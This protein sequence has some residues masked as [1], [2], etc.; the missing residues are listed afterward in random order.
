MQKS[1]K[2]D[3][4]KDVLLVEERLRCLSDVQRVPRQYKKKADDY[5]SEG[6]RESHSKRPRLCNQEK[7]DEEEDLSTLSADELR[8]RLKD[9]GIKTRVRNVTRLI[10]M[11]RIGLQSHSLNVNSALHLDFY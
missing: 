7:A 6:I 1:N 5:W 8:S 11:Y 10:D 2:W 4:A 9:L 3:A